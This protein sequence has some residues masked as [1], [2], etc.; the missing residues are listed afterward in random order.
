[1]GRRGFS[2]FHCPP[3]PALTTAPPFRGSFTPVPTAGLYPLLLKLHTPEATGSLENLPGVD[4]GSQLGPCSSSSFSFISFP[5]LP[6][7]QP[8]PPPRGNRTFFK[9][10]RTHT[11]PDSPPLPS[12]L[13]SGVGSRAQAKPEAGVLNPSI[14]GVRWVKF[15]GFSSPLVAIAELPS[16][17]EAGSGSKLQQVWV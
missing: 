10:L 4:R 15:C 6:P 2:L 8:L 13:G 11:S 9:F 5:V 1:M 12:A 16:L 17:A 7:P 3:V 14:S